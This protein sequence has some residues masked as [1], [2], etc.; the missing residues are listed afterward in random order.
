MSNNAFEFALY[1]PIDVYPEEAVWKE[2]VD[3]E[4]HQRFADVLMNMKIYDYHLRCHERCKK[5]HRERRA[6]HPVET[7]Q[8]VF[9][10]KSDEKLK[11]GQVTTSNDDMNQAM[12]SVFG[13]VLEYRENEHQALQRA[14]CDA[15]SETKCHDAWATKLHLRKIFRTDP[16][17]KAQLNS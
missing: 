9:D 14:Y 2:K 3:A 4:Q 11:P 10:F 6:N 12:G 16:V 17:A 1:K 7:L 5:Y 8:C 15:I 13:L